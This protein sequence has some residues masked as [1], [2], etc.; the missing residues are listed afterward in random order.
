MHFTSEYSSWIQL[1]KF[2]KKLNEL[3]ASIDYWTYYLKYAKNLLEV[4]SSFP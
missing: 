4:P 3:T 1:P 2:N